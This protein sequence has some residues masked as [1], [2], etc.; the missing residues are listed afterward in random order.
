V[1]S[2]S[3]CLEDRARLVMAILAAGD[4]PAREQQEQ[5]HAV[6][7]QAK[8][9]RQHVVPYAHHPA[10]TAV[11]ELLV[12]QTPVDLF[13]TA[14]LRSAW[15]HLKPRETLPAPLDDGRWLEQAADFC[16]QADLPAILWRGQE[17][18]WHEALA[19]LHH[20]FCDGRVLHFL[21]RLNGRRLSHNLFVVPN[22]VYPAL[23][24]VLVEAAE[25]LF[26]IVPPPKAYGESAPWPYREGAD[27][28]LSQS[29][30]SLAAHIWRADLASL[31]LYQRELRLHAAAT[32]ILEECLGEG[33]AMAYLVRSKK[34]YQLPELPAAVEQLQARLQHR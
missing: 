4:W 14:V 25:G 20:I 10:V 9:T 31:N 16:R 26:I 11:N 24:P 21:D 28:V 29:C 19:D 13:F 33:E 5:G 22:L 32:V 2:I 12:L 17:Q 27:W 23:L 7:P 1:S 3:V 15:P 6:H 30:R 34:Q 8:A 18:A